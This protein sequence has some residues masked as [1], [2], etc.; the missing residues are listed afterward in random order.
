MPEVITDLEAYKA[1]IDF[2]LAQASTVYPIDGG[3]VLLG[4]KIKAGGIGEGYWQGFGGKPKPRDGG[5]PLKTGQRELFEES[6]LR[7]KLKDLVDAGNAY[8]YFPFKENRLAWNMAVRLYTC[9]QFPHTEGKTREMVPQWF[10]I[11]AVPY[12]DMWDDNKLFLPH[13]LM[14]RRV[15]IHAIYGPDNKTV[16]DY[17]LKFLD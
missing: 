4:R 17:T 9:R 6:R 5:N 8:Y 10:D 7:V 13:V 3:R 15:E 12:Q 2:P 14:G 1:S 16:T 11:P